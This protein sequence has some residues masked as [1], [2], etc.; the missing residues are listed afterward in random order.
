[1]RF[2]RSIAPCRAR[3][4]E[5]P[6]MPSLV[7][8]TTIGEERGDLAGMAHGWRADIV[9]KQPTSPPPPPPPPPP[10][11]TKHD[12][13]RLSASTSGPLSMIAWHGRR[14]T[15]RR[16]HPGDADV[17]RRQ[18]QVPRMG[19]DRALLP[20]PNAAPNASA[21]PHSGRGR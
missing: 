1:V 17:S 15:T 14:P 5:R 4:I 2:S 11:L 8:L 19:V 21:I 12:A 16:Q 7:I 9:G 18:H 20:R 6:H 10:T 3:D 13:L